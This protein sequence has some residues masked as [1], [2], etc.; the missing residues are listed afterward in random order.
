MH[1]LR[2]S[3]TRNTC[4]YSV[5]TL[6]APRVCT[7]VLLFLIAVDLVEVCIVYHSTGAHVCI[8]G[9]SNPFCLSLRQSVCLFVFSVIK[10]A[11]ILLILLIQD[12]LSQP[13][14]SW[15]NMYIH[16][17]LINALASFCKIDLWLPLGSYICL[18]PLQLFAL[19]TRYIVAIYMYKLANSLHRVPKLVNYVYHKPHMFSHVVS[20][21]RILRFY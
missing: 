13:S 9:L 16:C 12:S 11:Q 5:H 18:K 8:A 14:Y 17:R 3:R 21:P 19:H 6:L 20:I 15:H 4:M 2:A 7:L 10:Y 1:F